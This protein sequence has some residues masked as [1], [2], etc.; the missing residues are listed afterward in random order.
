M[1]DEDNVE[2]QTNSKVPI[3]LQPHVYRK[4]QSGNPHGRPPGQSLKE[5]AR[6]KFITMTDDEKEEF[7]NGIPKIELF[8]MAE[9]NPQNDTTSGGQPITLNIVKYDNNNDT[10]SIPT[11]GLPS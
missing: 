2:Q 4:G 5:Y 11:E 8:K 6:N 9:G 1:E 7:F 10:P 3:Q